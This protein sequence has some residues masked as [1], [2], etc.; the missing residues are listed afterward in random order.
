MPGAP[1]WRHRRPFQRCSRAD[2]DLAPLRCKTGKGLKVS[3]WLSELEAKSLAKLDVTFYIVAQHG[4]LP[5]QGCAISDKRTK[6][7]LA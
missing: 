2:M 1:S 6:S 3:R 7:T 5:I 4:S